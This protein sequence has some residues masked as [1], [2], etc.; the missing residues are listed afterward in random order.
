MQS[1]VPMTSSSAAEESLE[2]T[3]PPAFRLQQVDILIAMRESIQNP[4]PGE[5]RMEDLVWTDHITHGRGRHKGSRMA[6]ILWDRLDDFISGEQNHTL[7]PCRF[8]A[9]VIRRNLPNSLRSPRA[10][11]PALVVRSDSLHYPLPL[12]LAHNRVYP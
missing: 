4:P 12:S 10:Y 3:D 5:F 2:H 1:E 11:S 9:E 7:Y 8:R 6:F